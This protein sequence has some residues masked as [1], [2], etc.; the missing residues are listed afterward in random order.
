MAVHF[1]DGDGHK[2]PDRPKAGTGRIVVRRDYDGRR[3][4]QLAE[5]SPELVAAMKLCRDG[6]A[7]ATWDPD[8]RT[9]TVPRDI[10]PC[11]NAAIIAAGYEISERRAD[12]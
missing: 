7:Y 12:R 4:F 3:T 10:W 1:I 9:W 2:L 6:H 11:V 5:H 8:A